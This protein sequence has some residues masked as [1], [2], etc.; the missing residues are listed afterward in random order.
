MEGRSTIS[1]PVVNGM[2]DVIF[3]CKELSGTID[4]SAAVVAETI[5]GCGVG[6]TVFSIVVAIGKLTEPRASVE[7]MLISGNESRG[8]LPVV[9]GVPAKV[10]E[11][12]G[13]AT[14]D[15]VSD[16]GMGVAP[17]TKEV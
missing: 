7:G 9:K 17:L 4:V 6:M 8:M 14:D 12:V 10:S 5:V 1:L 11:T 2:D 15:N 16:V 13:L 3:I